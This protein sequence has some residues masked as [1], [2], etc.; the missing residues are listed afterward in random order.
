MAIRRFLDKYPVI[1]ES[2]YVDESSVIIGDVTLGEDV[3]I[4]P[5]VVARGDDQSIIIG[6]R[7]NI[8]DGTVIHIS[9]DNEFSPGGIPT[10]VGHDVT[11]GHRVMLH[12]TK[13]GNNCLIGMSST[14]LDGSVIED[15]VMI[16]AGSLVPMG[17]RLESG[18]LYVGSPVKQIRPLGE[19]ER[20]F[21][22]YSA[23]HYV[24]TKN[25]FLK[26]L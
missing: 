8:Q 9:S 14:L 10:I 18:Y 2:A 7:T 4:W 21:I 12:A 3:S 13:I 1:A 23:K 5:L 20:F 15:D 26:S 22:E 16:G 19:K 25:N 6:D 24:E 17:K 11:V